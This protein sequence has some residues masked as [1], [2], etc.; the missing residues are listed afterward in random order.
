[1]LIYPTETKL[2]VYSFLSWGNWAA[3]KIAWSFAVVF[4]FR[5]IYELALSSITSKK[6]RKKRRATQSRESQLSNYLTTF[7]LF[8]VS[9][10][11][12]SKNVS[13][14]LATA[15]P[16]LRINLKKFESWFVAKI[17]QE[18]WIQTS[19]VP[20]WSL[21]SRAAIGRKTWNRNSDK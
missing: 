1:M 6:R 21:F 15:S 5:E 19:A 3:L 12:T 9:N 11:M 14:Y 16:I 13:Q 20:T 8:E 10:V 2:I 18:Y 4:K 17:T 7:S